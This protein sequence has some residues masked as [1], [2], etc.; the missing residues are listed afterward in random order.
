MTWRELRTFI[1]HLPRDSAYGRAE[2]GEEADWDQ[3]THLLA[4]IA[5]ATTAANYQRA[6]KKMPPGE[7]IKPPGQARPKAQANGHQKPQGWK[8][9][10]ALFD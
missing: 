10:D 3:Q 2:L 5:N 6:S 9:L 4:N 8:E 7:V 1:R